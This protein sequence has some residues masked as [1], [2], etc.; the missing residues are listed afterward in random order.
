MQAV[1]VTVQGCSSKRGTQHQSHAAAAVQRLFLPAHPPTSCCCCCCGQALAT[2][3]ACH[4]TGC[5]RHPHVHPAQQTS[6][7]SWRETWWVAL[8]QGG[9]GAAAHV[10]A[11]NMWSLPAAMPC[12]SGGTPL[13]MGCPPL[14][15]HCKACSLPY[16][17][18]WW[19]SHLAHDPSN[20]QP[21]I[22]PCL[23]MRW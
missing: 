6:G 12:C 9:E 7:R 14:L 8:G 5:G 10:V 2:S 19:Q 1:C 15:R 23:V 18:M 11:S 21:G 4:L 16:A 17:G 13:C 3:A 20:S 22:D